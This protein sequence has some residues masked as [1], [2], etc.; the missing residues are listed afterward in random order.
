VVALQSNHAVNG[1]P[2]DL[3]VVD[4]VSALIQTTG[5]MGLTGWN[6]PTLSRAITH[7]AG[8]TV[9]LAHVRTENLSLNFTKIGLAHVRT[10]NLSLNFTKIGL[11]HVRTYANRPSESFSLNFTK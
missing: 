2:F 8:H 7:E 6:N 10:E 9:G 5:S 4:P 11:A 3:A 1:D